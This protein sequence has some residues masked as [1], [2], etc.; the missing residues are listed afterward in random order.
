VTVIGTIAVFYRYSN[1]KLL[2]FGTDAAPKYN[3]AIQPRIAAL[4]NANL[5]GCATQKTGRQLRRP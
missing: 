3:R 1:P 5:R 2:S 4:D